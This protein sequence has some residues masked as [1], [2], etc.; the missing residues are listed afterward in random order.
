MQAATKALRAKIAT[1]RPNGETSRVDIR[2]AY[3]GIMKSHPK[4]M[5]HL[6]K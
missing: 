2:Q 4:T 6:A 1:A 5:A 3:K